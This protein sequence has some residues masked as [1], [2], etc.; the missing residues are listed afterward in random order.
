MLVTVTNQPLG[1]ID[2]FSIKSDSFAH[3]KCDSRGITL[4]PFTFR[5]R[6]VDHV[7]D[8]YILSGL[9]HKIQSITPPEF[10]LF[11]TKDLYGS[12]EVLLHEG[13]YC[14]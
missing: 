8:G 3:I 11:Q 13:F 5:L 7:Y 9:K 14:R 2:L 6:V 1:S 10:Q 12:E 4:D